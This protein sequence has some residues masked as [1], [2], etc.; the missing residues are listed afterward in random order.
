[1]DGSTGQAQLHMDAQ[2]HENVR[3]LHSKL[4]QN[5]NTNGKRITSFFSQK[6]LYCCAVCLGQL[7]KICM[8]EIEEGAAAPSG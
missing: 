4:Y 1:M 8:T 3:L 6:K 7:V 5:Q 2:A